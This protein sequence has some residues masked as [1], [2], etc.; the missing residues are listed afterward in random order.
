LERENTKKDTNEP[1][2]KCFRTEKSTKGYAE[3]IFGQKRFEYPAIICYA[4]RE[5]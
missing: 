5:V 4:V 3:T 2:K 1:G